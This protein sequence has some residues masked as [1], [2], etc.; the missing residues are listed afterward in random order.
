[1]YV[2]LLDKS[3]ELYK[4]IHIHDSYDQI[5][6][7][8]LE[9]YCYYF[10]YYLFIHDLSILCTV[11][12]FDHIPVCVSQRVFSGTLL[13]GLEAAIR[14][15]HQCEAL[16]AGDAVAW[17]LYSIL[18]EALTGPAVSATA[19]RGR[20]GGQRQ[21]QQRGRGQGGRGR[22]NERRGR[23]N[24]GG[25]RGNSSRGTTSSDIAVHNRFALLTSD[26]S[27]QWWP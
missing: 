25:R 23:G 15:G 3:H 17:Q 14:G 16:L 19:S 22:G 9:L 5:Y 2:I 26:D 10:I 8:I 21:A 4:N 27:Q 11:Y 12:L 7:K 1:M 6:Y 13:H 20:A 18:L 24:R